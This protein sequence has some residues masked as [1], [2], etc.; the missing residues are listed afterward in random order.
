MGRYPR[1]IMSTCVVPWDENGDFIEGLFRDHVRTLCENLTRHLYV[2]GTAG[3]GYAVSDRQFDRIVAAFSDEMQ[4]AG[5]EPMVGVISLS[6]ATIVER[7]ERSRERGVRRFQISLP[8]W[9]PLSD[10]ELFAFFDQVCGRFRDC[11]FLH[12]NLLRAKRLVTAADYARLSAAHPNLV[13]TKNSTDSINRI[14]EL[15]ALAP[16]LRHFYTEVGY[17]YGSLIAEPGLLIGIAGTNHAAAKQFFEAGVRRD[18]GR[19][20]AMQ[21]ELGAAIRD[22]VA[23]VG[24]EAH[25]DGAYDKML[26]KLFD[27]RFP[28]RLLS[29][30]QHCPE[31]TFERFKTLLAERYPNWCP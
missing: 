14:D 9:G 12:Y 4:A 15:E 25:I 3:E 29:P 8:S 19:L 24:A 13:A 23:L 28:L 2:F 1:C 30:Y 7:I 5:A 31:A 17:A 20:L 27:P 10:A 21:R 6:L 22:L 18:S 16:D 26:W 11:E